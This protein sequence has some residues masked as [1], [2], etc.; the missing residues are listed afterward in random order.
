MTTSSDESIRHQ[1]HELYR[2]EDI[3][4][5]QSKLPEIAQ[6]VTST[7]LGIANLIDYQLL[8]SRLEGSWDFAQK[9]Q[10]KYH[11]LLSSLG[12]NAYLQKSFLALEVV[13]MLQQATNAFE[14]EERDKI[15]RMFR[16][17]LIDTII[18]SIRRSDD[19]KC[20]DGTLLRL[21]LLQ[22]YKE[23]YGS[24]PPEDYHS[25]F[26]EALLFAD[27]NVLRELVIG[28]LSLQLVNGVQESYEI[29]EESKR[30]AVELFASYADTTGVAKLWTNR[31]FNSYEMGL[32]SECS[33]STS[34]MLDIVQQAAKNMTLK[35][36]TKD[37]DHLVGK[38]KSDL[39]WT[40]LQRR[41]LE[42]D[43]PDTRRRKLNLQRVDISGFAAKHITSLFPLMKDEVQKLFINVFLKAL[44]G[45]TNTT[46][47]IHGYTLTPLSKTNTETLEIL[48]HS[49]A[50]GSGSPLPAIEIQRFIETRDDLGSERTM[51][52]FLKATRDIKWIGEDGESTEYDKSKLNSH[53]PMKTDKYG[54][55]DAATLARFFRSSTSKSSTPEL[56]SAISISTETR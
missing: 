5:I 33:Y 37:F 45:L 23:Y 18:F 54:E 32:V 35:L 26:Y 47:V 17:P 55:E 40:A 11:P 39:L 43:P 13:S 22:I 28:E 41:R 27:A 20:E 21:Q 50:R 42:K 49:C 30:L 2:T 46:G 9:Y 29:S 14:R 6:A 8:I 44:T 3:N 24:L 19:T 1:I 25:I 34:S 4:L 16:Q 31:P 52:W 51:K 15:Y 7:R 10:F 48:L 53:E 12:S 36:H 38:I 56:K